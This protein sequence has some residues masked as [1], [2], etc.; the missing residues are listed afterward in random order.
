MLKFAFYKAPGSLTDRAIRLASG[1]RF[2]HVEFCMGASC[3]SASCISASKRDGAQVR[4]KQIIFRPGHWDF[5]TVSGNFAAA[6]RYARSQLGQPYNTAGAI[7][8]IFPTRFDVGHGLFCSEFTALICIAGGRHIAAPHTLTPG[9][10]Y[11]QLF[12]RPRGHKPRE[13]NSA[14]A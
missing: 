3:I 5:V 7:A 12:R 1:S 11:Q 4:E 2:S 6:Q 9:E 8:S 10:F 13:S 14:I